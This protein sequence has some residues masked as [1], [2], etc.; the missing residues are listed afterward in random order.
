MLISVLLI[1]FIIRLIANF[2]TFTTEQGQ[3]FEFVTRFYLTSKYGFFVKP[4]I[5]SKC[6]CF[7]VGLILALVTFNFLF[8]IIGFVAGG[9]K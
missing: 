9:F 1:A 7:W 5:C 6:F 4:L 2:V 8:I 3:I